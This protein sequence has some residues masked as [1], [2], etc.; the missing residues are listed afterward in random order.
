MVIILSKDMRRKILL[1]AFLI[2]FLVLFYFMRTQD[3]FARL[4]LKQS[5]LD[6][7]FSREAKTGLEKDA[8][9]VDCIDWNLVID[10]ASHP[11]GPPHKRSHFGQNNAVKEHTKLVFKLTGK[12]FFYFRILRPEMIGKIFSRKII[13]VSEVRQVTSMKQFVELGAPLKTR[14]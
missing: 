5:I 10:L 14:G 13:Q 6:S 9:T 11:L 12:S 1:S 2:P 8:K 7:F 3:R 4:D